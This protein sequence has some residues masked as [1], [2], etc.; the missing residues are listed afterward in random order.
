MNGAGHR[1]PSC[2]SRRIRRR[3]MHGWLERTVL[4]RF[5]RQ[6]YHCLQ[7]DHSFRDRP[8]ARQADSSAGEAAGIAAIQAPPARTRRRR[9]PRTITRLGGPLEQTPYSRTWA[10]VA[11][12]LGWVVVLAI[13]FAVRAWWPA[14]ET[15]VRSVD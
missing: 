12:G 15:V 9:R 1:C 10:Y 11:I 7:C 2:G 5:H 6:G 3:G 8:K 4:P 13:F 14:A